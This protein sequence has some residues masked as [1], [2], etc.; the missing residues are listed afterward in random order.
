M[1]ILNKLTVKNLKLNIKRTV[2][3]I[4]GIILSTALICA[5]AGMVTSFRQTLINFA[6][7]E[8]GNHHITIHNVKKDEFKYFLNDRNVDSYYMFG[9]LGYA[10]LEQS[11]NLYKP[12]LYILGY[13][14]NDF[15][16]SGFRLLDGRFPQNEKEIVITNSV[17]TNGEANLKIGDVLNLAVGKRVLAMEKEELDQ[18]NPFDTDEGMEEKIVD[19]KDISYTI[20][21][22]IERPNYGVEG[23]HAPGY[24]ALTCFHDVESLDKADVSL[25]FHKPA[26]Y[27]EFVQK[28]K[29][30]YEY[31]T[32]SDLLRWQFVG[33]S[34]TTFSTI[35][36]VAGVVIGIIILTSIFVIRNSFSISITEKTKQYGMLASIGATSKQ[37]KKNVLYEGFVIGLIAIPIG[38]VSG[39]FADFVLIIIINAL[40]GSLL[41]GIQFVYKVPFLPI[42]LTFILATVT[43]YLSVISS[44]RRSAKISPIE[45]I[46]NNQDIKIKRN[47]LKTPAII[48]KLF[49]TGGV[50]AHKNLKRSRKKYRTTVISLVVSIFVFISL[51]SFIHYG[52]EMTSIYY[53]EYAYN[54]VVNTTDDN[55]LAKEVYD[56][57][58]KMDYIDAYAIYR[59]A[60]L[61]IKAKDVIN[62]EMHYN[63]TSY[64]DANSEIYLNIVSLG[65]DEYLRFVDALG[66]NIE[67]Y[68]DGG[69][70]IDQMM[71]FDQNSQ[72]YVF[73]S[74]YNLNVGDSFTGYLGLKKSN[75]EISTIKIVA[76]TDK[77]PMGLE[78]SYSMSGY[79]IVSDDYMDALKPELAGDLYIHT[80][81]ANK[82]D[83]TIKKYIKE[84]TNK[85]IHYVNVDE[86][87]K[88]Q[89]SMILL[90]SIF[91]YGFI[92][93]ISLIGVTNIFNTITTNMN[94]RQKE[95]AM[96][97]SIGMTSREFNKMIV[98]E[99]VFYC[100][101]ALMIGIPL[102]ILGSYFMY[103]AFTNTANFAF[104][105]PIMSIIISI[106]VVFLLVMLIMYYSM[107]RINKQNI[108]ETIRKDNI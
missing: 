45:A 51:S 98:L 69:I 39:M 50:I 62:Q 44:A 74:I 41:N 76:K 88:Q 81:N 19:A 10:S 31:T 90:I 3:T 48:K 84:Q 75:E 55:D 34:D 53:K 77:R 27:K 16:L 13:E 20:V 80:N 52:F 67:D 57:I 106:V 89:N 46:R 6:I 8:N 59:H 17:N 21:G 86:E 64:D 26:Y 35:I 108:I 61:K 7:Y 99:T 92:I 68:K 2:V 14:Q 56:D 30:D 107:K 85:N 97:K 71:N 28:I 49:K 104:T 4:I 78:S 12:Y 63:L 33:L 93:V 32:N 23:T 100:S 102:G 60:Y 95:F 43:I 73:Q 94:L 5:V 65:E 24:T 70:L 91:L 18:N 42:F 54:M 66:G 101:K 36:M 103:N 47:K 11:T 22:F 15:A 38:I 9:R 83:E 105:V 58:L 29:N 96:L 37:I 87:I 82:L 40:M 1:N 79:L 25:M 72:K